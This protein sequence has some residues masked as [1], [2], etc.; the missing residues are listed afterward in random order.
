MQ[1]KSPA[2]NLLRAFAA[3]NIPERFQSTATFVH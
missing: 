2:L 3:A 1:S